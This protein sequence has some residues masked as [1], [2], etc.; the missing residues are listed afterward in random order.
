MLALILYGVAVTL[1]V[2][3]AVGV[4]PPRISLGWLGLAI[5]TFTAFLLPHLT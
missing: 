3:A 5:I 2:L 4:N 1:L